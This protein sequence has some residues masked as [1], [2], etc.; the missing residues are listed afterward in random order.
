MPYILILVIMSMGR[1]SATTAEFN[2]KENC[3]L[4][5][6]AAVKEMNNHIQYSGSFYICQEKG[7]N[8]VIQGNSK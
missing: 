2:Q 6:Q 1:I 7:P 8:I 3:E 5:G 4:A